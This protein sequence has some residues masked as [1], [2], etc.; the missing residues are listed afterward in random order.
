[1]ETLSRVE[2]LTVD[3]HT[4]LSSLLQPACWTA[5]VH[6]ATPLAFPWPLSIAKADRRAWP[7]MMGS[8]DGRIAQPSALSRGI[9][10]SI[11]RRRPRYHGSCS[12]VRNHL[13]API[14]N[15]IWST[16]G[17]PPGRDGAPSRMRRG[18]GGLMLACGYQGETP[19]LANRSSP[20]HHLNSP[21]DQSPLLLWLDTPLTG[22]QRAR[23]V[24]SRDI[25]SRGQISGSLVWIPLDL[26]SCVTSLS[27]NRDRLHTCV[28]QHHLPYDSATIQPGTSHKMQFVVLWR[29]ANALSCLVA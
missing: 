19:Q 17:D 3:R 24:E 21:D 4:R 14:A 22:A 10:S 29:L 2:L 15:G 8:G 16:S 23:D 11:C 28:A 7:G 6:C 25:G 20:C 18:D 1:M 5:A 26:P 9:A 13:Q 12:P 27:G